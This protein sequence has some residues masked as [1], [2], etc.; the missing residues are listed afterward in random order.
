MAR[1]RKPLTPEEIGAINAAEAE[2][3]RWRS[4]EKTM[5]TNIGDKQAETKLRQAAKALQDALDPYWQN[6]GSLKAAML[7]HAMQSIQLHRA[8]QSSYHQMLEGLVEPLQL[9]QW[10]AATLIQEGAPADQHV[11]RWVCMAADSWV[12][13]GLPTPTAKGRFYLALE[14]AAL[15][16]SIPSVTP[17]RA[18]IAL[19]RWK[20]MRQFTAG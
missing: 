7:V 15:D 18:K 16:K 14:G 2:W 9:I 13:A 11:G 8:P 5:P 19:D 3:L 4:V 6:P 12:G 1:Q 17:D 10:A 20:K